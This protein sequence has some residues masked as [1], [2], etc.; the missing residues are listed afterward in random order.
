MVILEDLDG[1][2]I[3]AE[4]TRGLAGHERLAHLTDLDGIPQVAVQAACRDRERDLDRCAIRAIAI[5]LYA[6]TT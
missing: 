5:R 4:P 3:T 2:A 6:I 1:S